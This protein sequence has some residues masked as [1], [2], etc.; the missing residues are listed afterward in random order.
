MSRLYWF[1][2]SY[3]SQSPRRFDSVRTGMLYLPPFAVP[4]I[5]STARTTGLS[6]RFGFRLGAGVGHHVRTDL[7]RILL[8]PLGEEVLAGLGGLSIARQQRQRASSGSPARPHNST[9]S[10]ASA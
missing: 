1:S 10:R 9:I 4:V 3:L 8:S 2:C 5:C 6:A 7:G